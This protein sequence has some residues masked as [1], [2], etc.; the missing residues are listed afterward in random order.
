MHRTSGIIPCNFGFETFGGGATS[1]SARPE[2][3]MTIRSLSM[4]KKAQPPVP[5]KPGADDGRLILLLLK[6][7]R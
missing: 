1:E 4:K 5:T 2:G 7:A 3:I 6:Q